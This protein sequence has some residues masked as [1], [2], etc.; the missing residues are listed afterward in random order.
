[1]QENDTTESFRRSMAEALAGQV[2]PIETLWDD[3]DE[4]A[5]TQGHCKTCRH[6]TRAVIASRPTAHIPYGSCALTIDTYGMREEDKPSDRVLSAAEGYDPWVEMGED[7]GCIHWEIGQ[8]VGSTA[9]TTDTWEQV[10]KAYEGQILDICRRAVMYARLDEALDQIAADF[11]AGNITLEEAVDMAT[12][13][14]VRAEGRGRAYG[15][16]CMNVS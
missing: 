2:R 14:A 3:I 5:T 1:M 16:S 13:A 7:F 15:H 12:E 4:E 9:M 10:L 11:A 6:W 8:E